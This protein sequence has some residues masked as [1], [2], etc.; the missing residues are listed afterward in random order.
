MKNYEAY[1]GCPICIAPSSD[2]RGD[3]VIECNACKESE[4]IYLTE[5]A[6]N[7]WLVL[8]PYNEQDLYER[9]D[10]QM[11]EQRRIKPVD[12]IKFSKSTSDNPITT[13]MI[14]EYLDKLKGSE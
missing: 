8:K 14:T 12:F 2:V 7:D 9:L 10:R 11:K 1:K 5:N 6:I 4:K 13:S 3:Y